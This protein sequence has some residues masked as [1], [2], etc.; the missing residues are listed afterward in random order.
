MAQTPAQRKA[1]EKFAK[2]ESAKRGKPQNSIKKGGE[3]GKS[4]I[5]TSWIIVLAFLICGGVI[6]EVLRMFF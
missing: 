6:F 2:L 4:P 1:N 5:S 3:K